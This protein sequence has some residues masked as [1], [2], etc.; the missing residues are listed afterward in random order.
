[1]FYNFNIIFPYLYY[2][3]IATIIANTLN[4]KYKILNAVICSKK[5]IEAAVEKQKLLV[6]LRKSQY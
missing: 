5:D 4:I 1:M 3:T 6:S 2:R